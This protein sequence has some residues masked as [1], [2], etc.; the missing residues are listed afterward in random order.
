VLELSD[1][2]FVLI[3]SIWQ[4]P[5]ERLVERWS[6]DASVD[7]IHAAIAVSGED[8][9]ARKSAPDVEFLLASIVDGLVLDLGCGYGRLAKYVLPR[10]DFDTYIGLDGSQTM[11]ALFADRYRANE[12]E[13]RTPLMLVHSPIEKIPLPDRSVDNVVIS[14]VLLHNSKKTTRRVVD[15]ARR[16]LRAGGRLVVL[17]DLPNKRTLAAVVGVLYLAWL[18]AIG[19]GQQNGPVRRY[20]LGET[21]RLFAAFQ[22][23]RIETKGVAI[24]PKGFPGLPAATNRSYRRAVHDRVEQIAVRKLPTALLRHLYGDVRVVAVR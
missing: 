13:H 12:M 2:S 4:R 24:L 9:E 22:D 7:P 11:L 23:V 1:P 3:D 15:E 21:R 18:A 10:R 20:S 5:S 19:R 6:A 16:V 14:A 8:A 17:S